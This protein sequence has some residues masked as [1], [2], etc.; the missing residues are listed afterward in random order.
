MVGRR[1]GYA[2]RSPFAS[3]ESGVGWPR[4]VFGEAAQ[5]ASFVIDMFETD[6][7]VTHES[8]MCSS[9]PKEKG[10][11]LE[12][13]VGRTAPTRSAAGRLGFPWSSIGLKASANVFYFS[14]VSSTFHRLSSLRVLCPAGS[15]SGFFFSAF[16]TYRRKLATRVFSERRDTFRPSPSWRPND[17]SDLPL[18][19][20]L[21]PGNPPSLP[22]A[23]N[24]A[25]SL[26]RSRVP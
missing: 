10:A 9:D 21:P 26:L 13:D 5:I 18:G 1:T 25:L 17:S 2:M 20:F 24:F 4:V 11:A 19:Y 15:F 7:T 8:Y 12:W 16:H 23:L 22:S 3:A 14:P 6:E